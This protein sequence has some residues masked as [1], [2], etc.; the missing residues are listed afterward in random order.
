M[1]NHQQGVTLIVVMLLLVAITVIAT[2]AVRQSLV[3]LNI[4]TNSQAEQLML[5][6]ADAAFFN[7]EKEDNI[8]QS[9]SSSGMFG[10]IDGAVNRDKEMVFCYRG[11]SADFFDITRA[12]I[13]EWNAPDTKPENSTM[14]KKGYCQVGNK[15]ENL[16]TSGRRA[17]MTQV[18]VK[19]SSQ[20]EKD[21]FFGQILGTDGETVKLED[22][23]P[24]RVFAV[25]IMPTL[26]TSAVTDAQINACLS[27]HMNEPTIPEGVVP[28]GNSADSVT[29]CLSSLGIPFESNVTE[30]IIAQDFTSEE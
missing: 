23:K 19:F 12:S 21:P 20:A 10:Y 13:I 2:I 9:L 28:V 15:D 14:G 11:A 18:A 16:F 30:Y 27:E 6:N 5:Q 8:I 22:A 25:S 26:G 29:T 17:V 3:S 7:I 4:A 1:K 24:V